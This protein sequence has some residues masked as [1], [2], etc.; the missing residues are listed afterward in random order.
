VAPKD[1]RCTL[2]IPSTAPLAGIVAVLRPEKNHELFLRVAA[3]VRREVPDAH[4]LIIGDGPRRPE[5]ET[6]ASEFGIANCVHFLGQRADIPE[7]LATL[8]VFILT[9]HNEAN[10]VSILEALA[11]GKPVVSTRVGSIPETVI[12][13]ETGFLIEPGDE[14]AMSRRVAE[15]L[16]DPAKAQRLGINGRRLVASQ[17]S[18]DSMVAGY[19]ALVEQLFQQKTGRAFR[20]APIGDDAAGSEETSAVPSHF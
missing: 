12:N 4:Y 15:L 18:V 10:P 17:W 9:S 1:L 19:E 6:L 5:L 7:L 11:A 8:D 13:G 16:L 20:N 3:R 2:G 14:S